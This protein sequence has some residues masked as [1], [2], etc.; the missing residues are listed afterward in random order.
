[1]TMKYLVFAG[2]SYYPS[3]GWDDLLEIHESK[4]SAINGARQVVKLKKA[5][6]AHVVDL[7]QS[8]EIYN[9]DLRGLA[10]DEF[11]EEEKK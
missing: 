8:K 9:C 1:M 7:E 10:M 6:W 5:D 3:G 4:Q 2:P 11:Y